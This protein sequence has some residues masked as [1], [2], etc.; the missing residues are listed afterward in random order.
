MLRFNFFYSQ[1][2]DLIIQRLDCFIVALLLS[3]KYLLA[4]IL[5]FDA[6]TFLSF[7]KLEYLL[8]QL[9]ILIC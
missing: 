7:M 8:R 1:L 9:I 5:N 4:L 6:H 2:C 3:P